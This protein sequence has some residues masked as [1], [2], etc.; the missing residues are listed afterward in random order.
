MYIVAYCFLSPK[1]LEYKI[2]SLASP[3]VRKTKDRK[4]KKK[5]K[6]ENP[7]RPQMAG[8]RLIIAG[9]KLDI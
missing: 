5:R 7:V 6:K 8:W 9:R 3:H 4:K 2:L 1:H